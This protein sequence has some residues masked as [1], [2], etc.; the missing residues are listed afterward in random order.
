MLCENAHSWPWPLDPKNNGLRSP[1]CR[2]LSPPFE[3]REWWCP[4]AWVISVSRELSE[5]QGKWRQ[6]RDSCPLESRIMGR[7]ASH[8]ICSFV[9][10][11]TLSF[12]RICTRSTA[13]H[14]DECEW[15]KACSEWQKKKSLLSLRAILLLN[16]SM[17][18]MS[19]WVPVQS[20]HHLG[21]S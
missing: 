3:G 15:K 6:S 21:A 8:R 14:L 9:V 18:V 4:Y 13:G 11:P 7:R 2:E 17:Q 5:S 20:P 1:L 16:T 10:V 19:L 12:W